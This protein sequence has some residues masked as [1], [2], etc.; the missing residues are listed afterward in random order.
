M[1]NGKEPIEFLDWLLVISYWYIGQSQLTNNQSTN[2]QSTN[3]E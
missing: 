2:N 3:N 1:G